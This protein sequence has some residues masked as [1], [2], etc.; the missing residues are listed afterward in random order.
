MEKYCNQTFGVVR[1]GAWINSLGTGGL[2]QESGN[3]SEDGE[4]MHFR[5]RLFERDD[6]WMS[7]SS[8]VEEASDRRWRMQEVQWIRDQSVPWDLSLPVD[9]VLDGNEESSLKIRVLKNECA[10][11]MRKRRQRVSKKGEK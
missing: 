9:N 7:V 1:H 10:Y 8:S 6:N 3:E 2:G 11:V 4:V 5:V